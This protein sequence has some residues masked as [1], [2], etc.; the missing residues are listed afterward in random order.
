MCSTF[1]SY[2]R[3]RQIFVVPEK[4][5]Q[6]H[7]EI[8]MHNNDMLNIE[9]SLRQNALQRVHVAHR[10]CIDTHAVVSLSVI[11]LYVPARWRDILT[12]FAYQRCPTMTM[13]SACLGLCRRQFSPAVEA[14]VAVCVNSGKVVW[15]GFFECIG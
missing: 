13:S 5:Q 14:F 12:T 9:Y 2:P 7:F 4:N 11:S 10:M 15:Y 8:Q 6:W 3:E 1:F